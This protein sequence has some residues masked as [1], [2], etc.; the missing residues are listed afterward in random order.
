MSQMIPAKVVPLMQC[1]PMQYCVM[2]IQVPMQV[3]GNPFP[4][5]HFPELSHSQ[6]NSLPSRFTEK[7]LETLSSWANCDLH[8]F[9]DCL[10]LRGV[11]PDPG[12]LRAEWPPAS[13]LAQTNS[14][15]LPNSP[16]GLPI[17]NS[18]PAAP[19][20][21]PQTLFA[22]S[23]N[24]SGKSPVV[25]QNTSW[26]YPQ[27][28]PAACPANFW[29]AALDASP[30]DPQQLQKAVA[31][32]RSSLLEEMETETETQSA[33]RHGHR[34]KCGSQARKGTPLS[35]PVSAT[36]SEKEPTAASPPTWGPNMTTVMIRNLPN[37][38]T[39]EDLIAAF[40]ER[41]HIDEIN[42][43]Y[44]VM[45]F[46][47][48][49]NK[50]FCFVNFEG[51]VARERFVDE[52]HHMEFPG[53]R[54]NDKILEVCAAAT[55]GFEANVLSFLKKGARRVMNPWFRPIILRGLPGDRACLPL[56]NE[57]AKDLGLLQSAAGG[58]QPPMLSADD[59]AANVFQ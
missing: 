58:S 12:T 2:P 15:R 29:I 25:S 17:P 10:K 50:G 45:D 28:S 13:G 24:S 38:T 40:T 20:Q 54:K 19:E 14:E 26:H 3:P 44:L 21:H 53:N 47:S 31:T 57:L 46:H 27:G 30:S 22:P 6:E 55:Q 4:P 42:Y 1:I 7:E 48:G 32:G 16:P 39:L 18:M 36:M 9:L 33:Q 49:F 56:T 41:N 51:P 5:K 37:R 8:A 34:P 23:H 11:V 52:F 43:I 35:G 59:A